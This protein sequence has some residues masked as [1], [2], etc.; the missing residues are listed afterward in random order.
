VDVSRRFTQP[1]EIMKYL[2]YKDKAGNSVKAW[3]EGASE[4]GSLLA[5]KRALYPFSVEI[6]KATDVIDHLKFH[7]NIY[8]KGQEEITRAFMNNKDLGKR[9]TDVLLLITTHGHYDEGMFACMEDLVKLA[10]H[11]PLTPLTGEDSEWNDVSQ[12]SGSPLWQNNRCSSVF[13]TT[14][15]NDSAYDV[16]G[17]TWLDEHGPFTNGASHTPVEFPYTPKKRYAVAKKK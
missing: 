11:Q 12:G 16:D 13:K 7:S 6:I 5:V 4:D 1:Y 10:R 2:I 3:L 14:P 15:S 8:R 17:I 9:L